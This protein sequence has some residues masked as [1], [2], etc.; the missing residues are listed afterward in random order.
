MSKNQLD[1]RLYSPG[2][3]DN[4][5]GRVDKIDGRAGYRW[6][7]V[8]ECKDLSGNS[9][10]ELSPSK[11]IALIGF[12]SD[13]GVR[14][15]KGRTGAAEG[16]EVLRNALSNLAVHFNEKKITLMDVG[17]VVCRENN[18]EKAHQNLGKSVERVLDSGAFLV[19]MGGGHET[20]YGHFKGVHSHLTETDQST[21]I[22]IIN[23]DSHFDIRSPEKG[24]NSGTP[25]LQ[26]ADLCD[27]T[28]IPFSYLALGIQERSNTK[29]LFQTAESINARYVLADEL[30]MNNISTLRER[31]KEFIKEVDAIYLSID[32][33]V[34][35]TPFAPGVSASY[36][37]GVYHDIV[38]ELT[39]QIIASNKVISCDLAEL[40]PEYDIDGRTAKL[41]A[42]LIYKIVMTQIRS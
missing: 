10:S 23:F 12:K 22:G 28:N 5:S 33:D 34:F 24:S 42:S 11:D 36:P 8:I 1:E 21:K 38:F 40:N 18:L 30:H 3:K 16:P 6:H 32:L 37:N 41:A 15:N 9:L 39:K 25:F 20:A 31:I 2:N 29:A 27:Q 26:I 17:D 35:A 19:V 13:E 4:W 7:Q 14:R